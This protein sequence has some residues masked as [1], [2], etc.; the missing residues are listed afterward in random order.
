MFLNRF[1]KNEL[2]GIIS[3]LDSIRFNFVDYLK[4]AKIGILQ[5]IRN[6]SKWSSSYELDTYKLMNDLHSS[7]SN[8]TESIIK[9]NDSQSYPYAKR[10]AQELDYDPEEFL[11]NLDLFSNSFNEAPA[12]SN[13]S[14]LNLFSKE[15]FDESESVDEYEDEDFDDDDDEAASQDKVSINSKSNKIKSLSNRKTKT[16]DEQQTTT[17]DIFNGSILSNKVDTNKDQALGKKKNVSSKSNSKS[18]KKK[19][20]SPEEMLKRDQKRE[21]RQKRRD[22][23]AAND[24]YVLSFDNEVTETSSSESE[25]DSSS[26][27]E[28]EQ[29]STSWLFFIFYFILL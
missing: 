14:T 17:E 16:I 11:L 1:E 24:F 3:Y 19:V 6:S 20:L 15:N 10:P 21:R 28:N 25:T 8:C 9:E 26:K 27:N 18:V 13:R 2:N 22:R 5:T 7:K 29:I 4:D 12:K 23:A